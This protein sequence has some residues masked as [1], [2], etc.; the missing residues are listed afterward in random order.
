[1]SIPIYNCIVEDGVNDITG[2]YAISFVD[3]PA[4]EV[5]FIA[6]KQESKNPLYLNR[7]SQKQI[8][9]GVV[10]KPEQL[11]YRFSEQLGEYYIK[12]SAEQIERIAQKMMKTGLA[13][14]HTTHQHEKPLKGNY[15]TELWIVENP[16]LDKSKAL[17]FQDLPK[18]TL[19]CSYKIED[20]EY[21]KNEVMTGHVKGF[22]L[23]GFFNQELN[24]TKIN[25]SKNMN[26][27]KTK[28][29]I[30]LTTL[31][32]TLLKATGMTKQM[33]DG[34]DAIVI[35]DNTDSG[36]AFIEYVLKD[37][38]EVKVDETGYA[39]LEG[40]QMAAGEHP[41]ADGNILVIDENGNFVET[42]EASATNTDPEE[43]TAKEALAR[44]QRLQKEKIKQLKQKLEEENA[45]NA[46]SSTVAELEAK[47]ADMQATIDALTKALEDASKTV[48]EV[49]EVAEELKK[50][51]PSAN[52]AVHKEKKDAVNMSYTD[53]MAYSAKLAMERR[54]KK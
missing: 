1:M 7:D 22:S 32:R 43:A 49:K 10:L 4:N 35:D 40:E 25:N 51:T 27:N 26:M 50:K 5:D 31:Q 47:I 52:P 14:Q 24:L 36:E 21:W 33:L 12:F 18:G 8:L 53:R 30:K 28:K 54:M 19:M 17:G 44:K 23:E 9:T 42:I 46:D 16:E 3:S 41:L 38:K 2:I 20:S 48:E 34:I 37:G 39:T 6:L 29:K 13:L 45:N 11:I 15:L